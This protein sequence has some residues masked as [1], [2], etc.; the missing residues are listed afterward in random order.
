MDV[1]VTVLDY[2]SLSHQGLLGSWEGYVTCSKSML[3]QNKGCES[4]WFLTQ[5]ISHLSV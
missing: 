1:S 5:N 3:K 2:P 4:K